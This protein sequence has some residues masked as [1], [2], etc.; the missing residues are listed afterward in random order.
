MEEFDGPWTDWDT[1]FAILQLGSV[2]LLFVLRNSLRILIGESYRKI[3][4]WVIII[5]ILFP[6]THY[7][8]IFILIGLLLLVPYLAKMEGINFI[9]F[10]S[11]L[12]EVKEEEE[13]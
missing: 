4:I 3:P 5:L 7:Y 8:S 2:I 1:A 6:F 10:K 9:C 13:S 12:E 11:D